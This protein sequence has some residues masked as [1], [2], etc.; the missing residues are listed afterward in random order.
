M[1]EQKPEF[2]QLYDDQ[3]HI[4][5]LAKALLFIAGVVLL[6]DYFSNKLIDAEAKYYPNIIKLIGAG[7]MLFLGA[8]VN[9]APKPVFLLAIFGFFGFFG[10]W[11]LSIFLV[12]EVFI[13]SDYN[14]AN[15]CMLLTFILKIC[16]FIFFTQKWKLGY[17]TINKLA[18]LK[19]LID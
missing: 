19:K 2:A 7:V 12:V 8:V 5:N 4:F 14:V 11:A 6:I 16:L 9:Y 18:R 3:N 15:I 1:K 17:H 13:K 10:I